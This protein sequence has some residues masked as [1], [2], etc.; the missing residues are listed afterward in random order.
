MS[1]TYPKKERMEFRLITQDD[2]SAT[3]DKWKEEAVEADIFPNE[4]ENKIAWIA[5][6]LDAPAKKHDFN[7]LLAY[8]VFRPGSNIAAGICELVLSDKGAKAGKWLK[9]LKVTLAPEIV[10][11]LENEDVQGTHVAIEVYKAAVLGAF[12]ERLNHDADTL[13][14]YGRTDEH[15]RFLVILMAT[16]DERDGFTVKKEGRWIVIKT[17]TN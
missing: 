2:F 1:K 9:M 7:K 15:L 12:T 10:T 16:L 8:G 17:T 5:Q 11:S 4:V 14:L 13:K 6:T 3:L